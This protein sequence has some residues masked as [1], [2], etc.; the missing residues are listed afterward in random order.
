[1]G[2]LNWSQILLVGVP[3]LDEHHEKLV[4]LIN[5]YSDAYNNRKS[6]E[7]LG[8]VLDELVRYTKFHFKAEEQ[9]LK[10][11][12]YP[13]SAAHMREHADLTRQVA[14]YQRKMMSSQP[15]DT[16]EVLYFLAN[17]LLKH[18]NNSDRQYATFFAE[19]GVLQ[20]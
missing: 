7:V 15:G 17:W 8:K 18:V 14:D 12:H 16:K 10:K 19:A 9:Y 1:M 5:N 13:H 4:E 2:L 3:V 20:E 6:D 11:Y